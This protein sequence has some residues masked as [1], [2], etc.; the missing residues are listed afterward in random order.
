MFFSLS[1]LA[2]LD[3]PP[4]QF[5]SLTSLILLLQRLLVLNSLLTRQGRFSSVKVRSCL[6]VL[7]GFSHDQLLV[8][9][10][11][12]GERWWHRILLNS[13]LVD[14]WLYRQDLCVLSEFDFSPF[15]ATL[16]F[17]ALRIL[18]RFSLT[19]ARLFASIQL[20]LIFAESA[21]ILLFVS[22]RAY[23]QRLRNLCAK[24]IQLDLW[25]VKAR[26]AIVLTFFFL[27]LFSH[28]VFCFFS[29]SAFI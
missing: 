27:I 21:K 11:S 26:E 17:P 4:T 12:C 25:T 9:N 10:I 2:K 16:I 8:L 19:H 6:C 1:F 13:M 29:I 24:D 20:L 22:C 23:E 28:R 3:L 15:D 5:V 14:L 18:L 7:L